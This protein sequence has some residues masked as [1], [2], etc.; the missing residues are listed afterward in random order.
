MANNSFTMDFKF[1][2]IDFV[3][4][5]VKEQLKS[6]FYLNEISKNIK[7]AKMQEPFVFQ[8]I[9]E[10]LNIEVMRNNNLRKSEMMVKVFYL[11]F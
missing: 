9:G 3:Q 10:K 1:T 2:S 8:N 5:T 4:Q 6:E 7:Q 11:K